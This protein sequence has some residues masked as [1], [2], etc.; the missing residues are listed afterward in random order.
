MNFLEGV[1][2]LSQEC[3]AFSSA[4]ASVIAQSL[5]IQRIINWYAEACN[6]IESKFFDWNFL[7]ATGS[8]TLVADQSVYVPSEL[9]S[10]INIFDL[11]SFKLDGKFLNQAINYD[12]GSIELQD[13]AGQPINIIIRPDGA[14][15]VDPAPD[16][17]YT[18]T[19]DYF[20]T[21]ASLVA[22]GDTPNIPPSHHAAIVGRALMFFANFNDA[23]ELKAQGQEMY[24]VG[25][26]QLE[27]RERPGQSQTYGRSDHVDIR[28]V[29][30]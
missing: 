9:P 8:L 28:V 5:N 2:R 26:Q 12:A 1:A 29:P 25:M 15:I 13:S 19:F 11:D 10:D 4:P 14:L 27:S 3:G 18:L 17:E 22:D 20:K 30:E 23:A 24:A 6:E 16:Q 21:A 7:W